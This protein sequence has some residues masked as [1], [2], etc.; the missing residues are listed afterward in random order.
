MISISRE[1]QNLKED[2]GHFFSLVLALDD[3]KNT[4]L[5]STT[6]SG[7]ARQA[8]DKT[9]GSSLKAVALQKEWIII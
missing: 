8:L 1:C 3:L 9:L 6:H 5:H 2:D 7:R 4:S